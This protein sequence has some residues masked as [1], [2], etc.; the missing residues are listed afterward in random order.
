M[1]NSKS[2]ALVLS[3]I[4]SEDSIAVE[5]ANKWVSWNNQR[6]PQLRRWQELRNYLFATDTAS[7]TNNSLP[8]KNTTTTPKLTQI[9]DNLFANYKDALLPR[10]KSI[11]WKAEDEA[12]YEKRDAIE[13]Y[14]QYVVSQEWFEETL[15]KLLYDFIDTGNV[16]V[17]PS[18]SDDRIVRE[19]GSISGGYVGPVA[20]RIS[21]K[22]IV[23]DPTA[24]SFSKTPKIIQ[25][26]VSFGELFDIIN[27]L[28]AE[29]QYSK[30]EAKSILNY[31]KDLRAT[32]L[33]YGDNIE[34]ENESYSV[35]GFGSFKEYLASGTVEILTFYGDMYDVNNGKFYRNARIT[36]LDR[37]KVISNVPN[38]SIFPNA[39]IYHTSWRV[40][41][42]NLWG[43]GPL[44]NLVGLQYRVDHLENLKADLYDLT[45]FPPLKV[46]GQVDDFKWGP[47]EKIYV[48]DA[49]SDVQLLSPDVRA[50]EANIEIDRILG[51]MEQMAGSPRESMGFRTPGEKTAFEVGRL[52]SAA[53]RIFQSKI[54]HFERSLLEP[55]MN[56][57][58][59][60]A[61]RNLTEAFT[62]TAED[63]TFNTQVFEEMTKSDIIGVGRIKPMAARHFAE[64]SIAIQNFTNLYA[65][66]LGSDPSIMNHFSG[67]KIAKVVEDLLDLKDFDVVQENVRISEQIEAQKFAA[68]AQEQAAMEQQ[69]P[70]GLSPEDFDPSVD[71]EVTDQQSLPNSQ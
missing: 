61:R 6:Q 70:A 24:A 52:E 51:L 59:E 13:K 15:D 7:T 32:V 47:F 58:L 14:M 50:L 44:E 42:D 27:S 29:D 30:D 40:R 69:T 37:H 45:A 49:Q 57:M 62:I 8:W 3:E 38:P 71:Q 17:I 11:V 12:S 68:A 60:L 21:P 65:S 46:K 34:Y 5:I 63:P 4:V 35:D 55:L 64:K 67:Y 43:M 20:N 54:R 48:Y 33:N 36:V 66:G 28:S 25:T 31:L 41:Q 56:G 26:F 19:D 53:A 22:S 9:R 23:F 18:W 16:F 2:K 10:E 39:P 1:Q